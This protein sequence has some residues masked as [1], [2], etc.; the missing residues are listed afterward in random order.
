MYLTNSV[1]ENYSKFLECKFDEDTYFDNTCSISNINSDSIDLK[2]CTI[3]KNN[4]D[5]FIL[6]NDNSLYKAVNL[7]NFGGKIF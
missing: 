5:N 2:K 3:S 6:S 7:I 4:F 1:I